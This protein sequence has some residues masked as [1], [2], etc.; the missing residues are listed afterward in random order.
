MKTII[1]NYDELEEKDIN[2]KVKRAKM[3]IVNSNNEVLLGYGNNNYQII[4]GHVEENESYDETVIR[5]VKEETGIELPLE[6]RKP[7]IE[8][9][10]L[11]KD[12][13]HS[14]D[15]TKFYAM[16]YEIQTDLKPDL[17][18]IQLTENEKEG[19]FEFRYIKLDEVIKEIESTLDICKNKAT[20]RDTIEVLKEYI[21]IKKF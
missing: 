2:K 9:D 12:Y 14:G 5:E 3:V 1:Y 11:C 21:K 6:H 13:P 8:I 15:N 19:M 10:Y 4:G 7:F 17:S 18:K 20:A 16:Y